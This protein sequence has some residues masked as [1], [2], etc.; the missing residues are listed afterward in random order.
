MFSTLQ[1]GNR[2]SEKA[3]LSLRYH[4]LSDENSRLPGWKTAALHICDCTKYSMDAFTSG[5]SDL[6]DEVPI[7]AWNKPFLVMFMKYS[8]VTRIY[9]EILINQAV[10]NFTS[11]RFRESRFTGKEQNRAN[12]KVQRNCKQ[13]ADHDCC[14][15]CQQE[16]KLYFYIIQSPLRNDHHNVK[17]V[18][19][20]CSLPPLLLIAYFLNYILLLRRIRTWNDSFSLL[21]RQSCLLP[22]CSAKVRLRKPHFSDLLPYVNSFQFDV[23]SISPFTDSQSINRL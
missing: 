6:R 2:G 22:V 23:T 15:C 10:D 5:F 11:S 17:L 4:R 1:S 18:L 21:Y 13:E 14:H 7:N 20:R 9:T 3:G 12:L 8:I 16:S 19:I